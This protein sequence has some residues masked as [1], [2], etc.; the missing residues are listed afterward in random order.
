MRSL[1][2]AKG[3]RESIWNFRNLGEGRWHFIYLTPPWW[4][5]R[6]ISNIHILIYCCLQVN[7]FVNL[8]SVPFSIHLQ[9]YHQF[10]DASSN[11]FQRCVMHSS[12]ENH[13][14]AKKRRYKV[15]FSNDRMALKCHGIR[16][17]TFN[18]KEMII[19]GERNCWETPTMEVKYCKM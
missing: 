11:S 3:F 9:N 18:T 17:L 15:H 10:W 8:S 7:Q 19:F 12:H 16:I 1:P 14:L 13:W 4:I 5:Y 2:S 6:F